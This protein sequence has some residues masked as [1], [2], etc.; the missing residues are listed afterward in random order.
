MEARLRNGQFIWISCRSNVIGT[1][2]VL[3][4]PMRGYTECVSLRTVQPPGIGF[5]SRYSKRCSS[6]LSSRYRESGGRAQ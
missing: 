3:S 6:R 5:G 4:M 1:G 2:A